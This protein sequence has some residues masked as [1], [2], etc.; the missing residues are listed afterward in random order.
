M[1]CPRCGSKAVL[2][3]KGLEL[4]VW[5]C[6]GRRYGCGK[7]FWLKAGEKGVGD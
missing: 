4:D 3:H 7:R 2:V 6:T 1:R 5:K